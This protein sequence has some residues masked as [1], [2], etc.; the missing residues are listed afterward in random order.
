MK[1][2][3]EVLTCRGK[4][5]VNFACNVAHAKG[6]HYPGFRGGDGGSTN[7]GARV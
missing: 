6:E 2:K 1:K 7:P 5:R 3:W 4:T